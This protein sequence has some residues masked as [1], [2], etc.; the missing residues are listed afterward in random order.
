MEAFRFGGDEF[1][2]IST[3]MSSDEVEKSILSLRVE[4]GADMPFSFGL[5]TECEESEFT[6]LIS[7][8]D[9]RMYEEKRDR[10][11]REMKPSR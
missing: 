6:T 10:K 2:V 4:V 5:A 7:E 9:R 1:A 8:A 11:E 3:E